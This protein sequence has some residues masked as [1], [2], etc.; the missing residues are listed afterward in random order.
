MKDLELGRRHKLLGKKGT[1]LLIKKQKKGTRR[2]FI[3]RNNGKI[4]TLDEKELVKL[5]PRG[6]QLETPFEF[7]WFLVE[8]SNLET[9]MSAYKKMCKMTFRYM[10]PATKDAFKA[11]K[12]YAN[13]SPSTCHTMAKNDCGELAKKVIDKHFPERFL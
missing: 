9:D 1:Y 11:L 7:Y 3:F 4:L 8:K 5:A 6:V 10:L 13:L 12:Y 2:L